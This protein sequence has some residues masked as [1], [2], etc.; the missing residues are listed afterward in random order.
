LLHQNPASCRA[1]FTLVDEHTKQ[2]AINRGVEIGV[3]EKDVWRLAAKF[4]GDTLHRVRGLLHDDLA[5]SSAS[6]E[7]DLVHIWCVTR[8]APAVSP[9]P[10]TM[11]TAPA[12]SPTSS[13]HCA[14][15]KAVSG[16]C[17]AGFRTQVHPAAN[18]G[19]SFQAAIRSG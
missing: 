18:A 15:S 16:V 19:A 14:I 11:F 6:C 17:S 13:N 5:H 2:C 1:D 12:G 10:V 3:C 7:R 4:E 9:N 8:G